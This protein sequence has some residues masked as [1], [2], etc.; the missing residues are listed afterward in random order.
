M[1][2]FN[3]QNNIETAS[4]LTLDEW[5]ELVRP[6]LLA[7][8]RGFTRIELDPEDVVQQTLSNCLRKGILDPENRQ[9]WA[10]AL[11]HSELRHTVMTMGRSAGRRKLRE[12]AFV[13]EL[14]LHSY[15]D[16]NY[17]SEYLLRAIA[18]AIKNLPSAQA[19]VVKMRYFENM[20]LAEIA[21][22]LKLS[23][24]TVASRLRY[25]ISR[26][27]SDPAISRMSSAAH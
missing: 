27:R 24:N 25:A 17:D 4:S 19:E 1:V 21:G 13:S 8:A 14:Q 10:A 23:I 9:S 5:I 18:K 7:C 2:S 15:M 16:F 26:L 11:L 20:S 22:V 6:K 12:A 3:H